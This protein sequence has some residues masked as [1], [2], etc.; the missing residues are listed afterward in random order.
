MRGG[1]IFNG[2]GNCIARVNNAKNNFA[3]RTEIEVFTFNSK[4]AKDVI[5]KVT[6]CDSKAFYENFTSKTGI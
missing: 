5:N 3:K 4:Y 1:G 6:P 2:L